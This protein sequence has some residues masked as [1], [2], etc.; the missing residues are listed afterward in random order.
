MSL[1]DLV[2][3]TLKSWGK[4]DTVVNAAAIKP[5]TSHWECF[6]YSLEECFY[7]SSMGFTLTI[8]PSFLQ[9]V[10]PSSSRLQY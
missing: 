3:L 2:F 1:A 5:M 8:Y 4:S 7:G 10:W 9:T 6:P